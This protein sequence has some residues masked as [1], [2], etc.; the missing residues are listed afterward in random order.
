MN[1]AVLRI[2]A[3]TH[4][5]NP[6]KTT[7]RQRPKAVNARFGWL[8]GA[9]RAL[10]KASL[11]V[12]VALVSGFAISPAA[13]AA[14][15]PGPN[16]VS[17]FQDAGFK[18]RCVVKEFGDYANSNTIGLPND[19]ISSVR[20]GGNAQVIVCKDNDFKGDCILLNKDVS[21]LNDRRVGNDQVSSAK[22]QPLG[23]AQ[24][25]P[26]NRQVSFF[27]NADFLGDCVVKDIG[28][29]ANSN[30]IGLPNDS[31]SSVRV[32]SNAQAIVC[33]DND[34]KGD[35]I[36]LT[37]DLSF[38]NNDRVGNDQ[39]SSVRIQQLG[40]TACPPGNNQV[41]FFTDAGFLG[42]CVV[43]DIGV[44]ASSGAIGLPN[45][46]ISSVRVGGNVQAVVC[47]DN[48]FR[49]DCI[50]LTR[51]VSFLNNDRVGNDQ[52]S[53]AKVQPLGTTECEPGS[54][55]VSFFL[56]ADFLAPCVVKDIGNYAN[57]TQI[58]LDD[59]GISGIKVG[60]GAIACTYNDNDFSG[61]V[62]IF[63]S[64]TV[65]LGS[66]ND[67]IASIRV[68]RTGT[69]CQ[70]VLRPFISAG[71]EFVAPGSE[72]RLLRI[73]GN[74]FQPAEP[75][76]L[77]ITIK[78][79]DSNPV[80]ENETTTADQFGS[81]DFKFSGTGGGVCIIGQPQH[82]TFQVQGTG[83]TSSKVSNVAVTGC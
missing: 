15:E 13:Q 67:M 31:I 30:A 69:N 4:G 18:G 82:E 1:S 71:I 39:I 21:F 6:M 62:S 51:D 46:S 10:A 17:F 57:A 49:G 73:R 27:T 42:A 48:N 40:T 45:D 33:K 70:E 79:G 43:K 38:L 63:S 61:P 44:Y 58:G 80:T 68:Q 72:F 24:C 2:S 35:C 77:Q 26:G 28:D 47:K 56:H 36:L 20:V 19:S 65:F 78:S 74:G 12:A 60:P 29:Y 76:R 25:V 34:F 3:I 32:G 23:M 11:F 83:L 81:V 55:Q 5:V 54:N 52:V 75:V 8:S 64:S 37:S 9:S 59:R 16:E 41:S 66:D 53:S 50:L 22:V 14:C 7:T